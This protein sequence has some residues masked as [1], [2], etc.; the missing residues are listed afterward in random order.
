[1]LPSNLKLVDADTAFSP[2]PPA[3]IFTI[4][5]LSPVFNCRLEN[6]DGATA[7]PLCS[8]T[9]LRGKSFCAT[10][11]SS[12]EHGSFASVCFPLAMINISKF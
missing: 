4:S 2:Y 7:S 12:I 9:T 11:N 3:T 1:M 6:S 10:K 5:S 8:T